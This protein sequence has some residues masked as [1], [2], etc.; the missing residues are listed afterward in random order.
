MSA[1][2]ATPAPPRLVGDGVTAMLRQTAIVVVGCAIAGALVGGIGGRLAMRVAALAA[3]EVR[4]ALTENGNVVGDITMPGTIALLIFA[5][6]GSTILGAGA[7]TVAGPWLPRPTVAR[8]LLFGVFLLVVMGSAVVDP[9]NPDFVILGDPLMN[10]GMFSALFIAFGLVAS[11]A[12]AFVERRVPPAAALSSRMRAI[13]AFLAL[14]ALAGL[15]VLAVGSA[16]LGVP[17]VGA[18]AASSA[19][20]PLDRRGLHGPARLARVV[21][22]VVLLVVVCIASADYV[23]GIAT[24]L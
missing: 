2:V 15:V 8:G 3:P 5:G 6:V 4:G 22:T 13:T 9:G 10:V 23:D 16:S 14:P 11:G 19:T 12:V 7:Y 24:I 1:A 21:A 20:T 18:W 17:L